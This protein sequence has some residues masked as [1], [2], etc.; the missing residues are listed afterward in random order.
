MRGVY[1]LGGLFAAAVGQPLI[2]DV[3]QVQNWIGDSL[4]AKLVGA[5]LVVG[6]IQQF[7]AYAAVRYTVYY[8]PEFDERVD[9]II[10]G[11]ASGLGYATVLNLQYVLGNGGVNLGVGAIHVA[12]SALAQASFAGVMGY[13]L[14]RAKFEP[15]GPFWL[16]AGLLIAAVLNGIVS[17]VLGEVTSLN[18]TVRASAFNDWYGLIVAVVVAGATFVALFA[19][20]RR[21]NA[22]T[23]AAAAKA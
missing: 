12:I 3:F 17:Y 4:L 18:T 10:Y 2:R 9:G 20:I 6:I 7:L 14:G 13:F 21:L 11:A 8:S 16:P 1:V 19:V 23:L 5:I 15:M 22:A